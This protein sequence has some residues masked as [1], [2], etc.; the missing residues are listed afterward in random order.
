MQ[1][2]IKVMLSRKKATNGREIQQEAHQVVMN[3]DVFLNA[4]F[5]REFFLFIL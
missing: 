4:I 1:N 3:D 2:H 5:L